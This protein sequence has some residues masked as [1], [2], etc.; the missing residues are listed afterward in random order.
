LQYAESI[1]I[2]VPK[3]V[4]L[5]NISDAEDLKALGMPLIIKP[6]KGAGNFGVRIID[7]VAEVMKQ[8]SKIIEAQEKKAFVKKNSILI[9]DDSDPIVQEF[10]DGPVVDA[11]AIADHGKVKT[12]LTQ[13]RVKTL[14]PEGGYGVMNRTVNVQEVRDMAGRLLT[15]L[16]WHG[17]AQVEFKYDTKARRYK[18]M[19]INPKFWGTLALSVAAGVD[20]PDLAYRIALGEDVAERYSFRENCVY[21]WIIPNELRHVLQSENRKDAF[22]RYILDFSK[23]AKYNV[24]IKDPLPVV[25]LC[26]KTVNILKEVLQHSI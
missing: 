18:L 4:L 20:F 21:R 1:G 11:C 8:K 12:I 19:E 2:N 25:S 9:Y 16:G 6:R 22:K 26:L 24:D 10:V 14:P 23:P 5:K 13:V 15:E 17:V 7:D 3:T